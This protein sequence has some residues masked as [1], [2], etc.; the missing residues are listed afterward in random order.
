MEL[1]STFCRMQESVQRDRAANAILENIRRVA[2]K[3]AQAWSAVALAAEQREA[4]HERT[5]IIA[6]LAALQNEH[7]PIEGNRLPSENPDGGR[8]N[9]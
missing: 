5:R 3:A 9:P 2:E 4:R 8:E 7:A 1:T 6:D